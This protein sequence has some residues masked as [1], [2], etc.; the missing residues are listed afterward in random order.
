MLELL[1][2]E[3]PALVNQLKIASTFYCDPEIEKRPAVE[4]D[5]KC[6]VIERHSDWREILVVLDGECEMMLANEIFYL[7]RGSVLIIDKDE[8]HQVY[9]PKHSGHGLHL[10]ISV[11]PEHI[12]YLP[13]T[14]DEE[15][16][17]A[18]YKIGGYNHYAPHDNRALVEALNNARD[19]RGDT[20]FLTNLSLLIQLQTI[21]LLL[22]AKEIET[23]SGYGPEKR[24]RFR[25][26]QCMEYIDQ[27]CGR[28][29]A[30][31]TLAKIGGFSRT[32]FLRNF[33]RYAGCTV[34]EYVN[35]QRI[36]R[37]KSLLKQSYQSPHPAPL[38]TCAQEL[39][40]AS[41]AVFA[42]WRKQHLKEIQAADD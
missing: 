10:W 22:L 27:Q 25:I 16:F 28:N 3:L 23:Y 29:C 15:G 40:F 17:I 30:V 21:Q 9:Y 39:G 24:N 37:Y 5:R 7:T 1:K 26:E 41:P 20:L 36:L 35:R 6:R 4:A 13:I 14:L 38:K 34:L 2:N 12:R 18:E 19:N 8:D 42:R 11:M 31:A 33:T 32:N